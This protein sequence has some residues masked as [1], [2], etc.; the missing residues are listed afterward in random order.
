MHAS[1]SFTLSTPLAANLSFYSAISK[2]TSYS[3]S[4]GITTFTSSDPNS[5]FATL[6]VSTDSAGNITNAIL[7]LVE[8][9]TGSSPH[10]VGDRTAELSIDTYSPSS[11]T[12]NNAPCVIVGPDPATF[13][14]DSCNSYG[15]IGFPLDPAESIATI[16]SASESVSSGPVPTGV[17]ALSEWG[18]G[19]LTGLLVGVA[20]LSLRRQGRLT[21]SA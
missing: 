8:W 5:R 9:Q 19:I 4:N 1:G 17:P 7:E 18:G 20:W 6:V 3:F 11:L 13:I 10:S 15:P 14:P 16:T 2:L 12:R 21:P